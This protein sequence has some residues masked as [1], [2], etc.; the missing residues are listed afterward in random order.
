MVWR[1]TRTLDAFRQLD[2]DFLVSDLGDL[3]DQAP[4]GDDLITP[5]EAFHHF[6]VLLGALLLRADEKEIEH[7]AHEDE[8]GDRRGE[9][10]FHDNAKTPDGWATGTGWATRARKRL[11]R[12]YIGAGL[13]CN[14]A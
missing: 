4:L 9:K 8:H 5:F 10:G 11:A 12:D 1:T 6:P 14:K 3:A 7:Q 13:C 2:R